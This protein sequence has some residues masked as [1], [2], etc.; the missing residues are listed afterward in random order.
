MKNY[1]Y[2]LIITLFTMSTYRVHG[3]GTLEYAF[4][5]QSVGVYTPLS[6]PT[7]LVS[8]FFDDVN[9]PLVTI[10]SILFGGEPQSTIVVSTNGWVG[11]GAV[12]GY[13]IYNPLNSAILNANGVIAPL[14]TDLRANGLG[15]SQVGYEINGSTTTIEWKNLQRFSSAAASESLSFQLILDGANNAIYFVYDLQTNVISSTHPQVGMKVG[16]A[17]NPA[18]GDWANRLVDATNNWDT[19]VNGTSISS[20]C[21]LTLTVPATIPVS[22][23]MYAWNGGVAGCTDSNACNYN[24]DAEVDNGTC[25]YCSCNACGCTDPAACNYDE[26][27]VV[28]NGSCYNAI[29]LSYNGQ[30]VFCS[31]DFIQIQPVAE[32][33][34]GNLTYTWS[35][36]N[37]DVFIPDPS[38]SVFAALLNVAVPNFSTEISVSL[39]VTD[40]DGCQGF[41]SFPI[42]ADT[43]ALGCMDPMACN[44]DVIATIDNGFC[45][46]S[47]YG[48]LDETAMNYNP[49]A[50]VSNG[51]CVY[52]GDGSSCDNP[53]VVVCG[54]GLYSAMT[55]GVLNDNATSGALACGGPS[56]GGQRWYVYEAPYTSEVT[57]STINALTN[58]DTYLKVYSGTCG[59][60]TCV[61]QNDD[62]VGTGF[63]SQVVFDAVEGEIYLIRVGGFVTM[64]G[65]FGLTIDCGGGCLDPAAC[66][67]NADSPFDDGSCTY[68]PDCF[69]CTDATANNYDPIAV[70]NQGCTYN[71]E[72]LVYH[73]LN[74][75]GSHQVNEPG[76]SNWPVYIPQLNATVYSNSSGY[77]VLNLPASNFSLELMNESDNWISSNASTVSIDVP[78]AME[79]N[80][81]LIPSTGETFFVAFPNDGFWDIIH[82][83]NGYEAG[84]FLNNTGNTPLN[85]TLTMTCSDEFLPEADVYLTIAPDQ[86]APGF[87]Q[88]NILGFPAGENGLFSFHIPGPGVD[89]IGVTY[90]F[91]FNLILTDAE[92][93]EIYN[94][95]WTN[96]PFIACSYDPND[97]TATPEGIF[98]PHYIL[99]GQRLQYRVRFQNTGNY[100]AEDVTILDQLDTDVFDLS[101]F[102]PLY[103]SNEMTTCLHDD[104]TIDFIFNDIY[105]P[106]SSSNEE[107]SHGFVVYEV[108]AR[109]D[110]QPETVLYNQAFIFFDA[111]PA[112][113]TNEVFH[114]IFDCESFTGATGDLN[115]CEGNAVN[116][117]ATQNYTSYYQWFVNNELISE[118][119][120]IDLGM[121]APG[122]YS[123]LLITGNELCEKEHQALVTVHANPVVN[124][125]QDLSICEGQSVVLDGE[126]DAVIV[127]NGSIADGSEIS[128][129]ES[130]TYVASVQDANGCTASDEIAV[131]V[132]PLPADELTFAAGTLTASEGASWQW[133]LDG[134]AIAGEN[135]QTL[136]VL[137][138]GEYYV[139]VTSASGCTTVSQTILVTSVDAKAGSSLLVYPNPMNDRAV[140]T[141]PEGMHQASLIDNTGRIVWSADKLSSR[142]E[143]N[144]ANL[145]SGRYTL[146]VQSADNVYISDVVVE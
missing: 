93:N 67:Y 86:V 111:N 105:L 57:V 119:A 8:G 102:S 81:G 99:P 133:Y 9:T 122:D 132:N 139:V 11:F 78:S 32:P 38:A 44:Y 138:S 20:T 47:C 13:S 39:A 21:R 56:S 16:G 92:G 4:S 1:F 145:A 130:G 29:G 14:G 104:G 136:E 37:P 126:S 124:A 127:W 28:D 40:P 88:W 2:L 71:P 146:K 45:D 49:D 96:T 83:S 18:A 53:S 77:V 100:Y 129:E 95:S 116:L 73:D 68:G 110:L 80:F 12:T 66:N 24:A 63:Q 65:T 31:G 27:A 89:N 59:D 117:D 70:Y 125:G 142:F 52:P 6:N 135:S 25:D 137:T 128:P 141:L 64:Q 113:I 118:E 69:G 34:N 48:C 91:I 35:T 103:A 58:F 50:T 33:N 74:G 15:D 54:A 82:C 72:I 106:D 7:V 62:I 75:D 10:P 90:N 97:I 120:S 108:E 115:A 23:L 121:L 17:A 98:E 43:C 26:N 36:D 76:L 22:G 114:T 123:T 107:G 112:I 46:Y 61:G 131:V 60:L 144:A 85:G 84:V 109:A 143:L 19:S 101:T 51:T 87:A 140:V 55:V 5:G 42:W 94:E 79:A 30:N 134:S 41:L 3:Q